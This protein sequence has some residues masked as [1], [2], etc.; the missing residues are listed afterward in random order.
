MIFYPDMIVLMK[1][2][3]QISGM[4]PNSTVTSFHHCEEALDFVKTQETDL[5]FICSDLPSI[6]LESCLEKI[7]L[8]SNPKT[9][10][11]IIGNKKSDA[12]E[13]FDLNAIDFLLYPFSEQRLKQTYEKVLHYFALIK[14]DYKKSDV[15]VQCMSGFHVYKKNKEIQFASARAKELFAYLVTNKDRRLTWMQIADSLWP[16]SAD[17]QKLMN[18]FH[19]ASYA[20]RKTLK[21][22]NMSSIFVYARNSYWVDSSKFA[23]DYYHLLDVYRDYIKDMHID[24]QIEDIPC[25]EFMENMNYRWAYSLQNRI[26]KIYKDFSKDDRFKKLQKVE[27]ELSGK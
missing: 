6:P 11:I 17:D 27:L 3:Q 20:L 23:C 8:F 1:L 4:F 5:V 7:K 15:F 9:Q 24:F 19:V 12:K 14:E 16:D 10:F 18:N 25:G 26:E 22:Y 2:K 13:A 21:K